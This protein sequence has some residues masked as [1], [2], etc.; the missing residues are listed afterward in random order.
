MRACPT[1]AGAEGAQIAPFAF[2]TCNQCAMIGSFLTIRANLFTIDTTT[3]YRTRDC[4]GRS[5]REWWRDWPDEARQ[6][7]E[8]TRF[9][10][11]PSPTPFRAEWGE[12]RV[13]KARLLA[14]REVFLCLEIARLADDS[15]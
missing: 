9:G 10:R 1:H 15:T 14:P 7:A 11:V 5:Y 3:E 2:Q 13:R 8:L 12:M 6:P 4:A